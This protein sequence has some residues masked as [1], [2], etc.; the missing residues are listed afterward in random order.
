MA[1]PVPAR[2]DWERRYGRAAVALDCLSLLVADA[3]VTLIYNNDVVRASPSNIA[4]ALAVPLTAPIA[5]ALAHAW[6]PR[7]LG[8]GA[9]EFRRVGYA[10]V[11]LIAALALLGYAAGTAAGQSWVFGALPL[12]AAIT[13]LGRYALRKWLH[14]GRR[15][16]AF[17]RSVLVAGDIDSVQELIKRTRRD[18][19]AGWEIQAVCLADVD[20]AECFPVAIDDVPVV[21]TDR[22]IVGLVALHGYEAVAILPSTGWSPMRTQRLAW[23]LEGTGADLLIAPALMDIVGPRLHIRPVAGMPLLQLS[24]PNFTRPAWFVKTVMDRVLALGLLIVIAP[25]MVAI[26]CAIRLTSPGPA[27]FKQTRV[28]RRGSQFEMFKFRSM[29]RDA[30]DRLADLASANEGAGVLFKIREDPRVTRVGHFIRRYSLDELPQLLNVVVGQMSLVGPR[31]PLASEVEQY[32]DG[33]VRR[34]L[35]VKPGLTGLWQV[36][37]RSNLSWEESVRMDL[38]YVENWSMALDVMILWKTAA[39]VVRPEGAF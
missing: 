22:D 17:L 35:F 2:P 1:T 3:V 30:E 25:M 36:S 10:Y 28:G 8:S 29:V 11:M 37:G 38:R 20:H 16:G 19:Y 21:G 5:L 31:P 6:D 32:D 26:G 33:G 7:V 14:S 12:A 27:L 24:A 18:A 34:R 9:E 39:A 4:V 23:D 13:L 15:S